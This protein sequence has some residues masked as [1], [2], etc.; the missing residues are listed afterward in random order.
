LATVVMH[1]I[2]R[3][4]GKRYTSVGE[5]V[6][7]LRNLDEVMPVPYLPDRS[8]VGGHYRQAIFLVLLIIAICLAIIAFGVLAQ[9]AHGVPR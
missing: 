2:R 7:D 6:H 3:D 8:S 5:M 4:P 1:A 9:V